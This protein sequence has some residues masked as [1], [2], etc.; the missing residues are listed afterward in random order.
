MIVLYIF[1]GYL[2]GLVA[3]IVWD[4][5]I[6]FGVEFDGGDWPPMALAVAVWPIMIPLALISVLLNSLQGLKEKRI[7]RR[8]TKRK[9]RI[10]L[11]KEE[12]TLLEQV[13]E[14]LQRTYK[15]SA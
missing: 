6:G 13:E 14:E 9:L 3:F 12:E 5:I 1:A 4:A 10:A 2:A 8:E 15:K 7:S 11:Q